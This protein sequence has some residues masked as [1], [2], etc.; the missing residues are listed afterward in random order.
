MGAFISVA[1]TIVTLFVIGGM[2]AYS[3]SRAKK[4]KDAEI[5]NIISSIIAFAIALLAIIIT[6]A[7]L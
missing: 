1:L 6:I 7:L 4:C 5:M 3:A 2:N